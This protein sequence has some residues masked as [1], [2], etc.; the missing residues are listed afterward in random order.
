MRQAKVPTDQEFRRLLAVAAQSKHPARNRAAL[1]LSYY[2]G[3]REGEIAALSIADAYDDSFNVR[4]QI[5]LTGRDHQDQR[6][7]S[8]VG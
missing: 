7:T 6:S 4:D 3:M 5:M 8:S 1:M 2:A